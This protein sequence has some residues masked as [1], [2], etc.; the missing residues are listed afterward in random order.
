MKNDG[1]IT[2][3]KDFSTISDYTEKQKNWDTNK[4]THK[5]TNK[6]THTQ[7]NKQK[8]WN[9]LQMKVS[10]LTNYGFKKSECEKMSNR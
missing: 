7:T 9:W 5:Q 10:I 8:T 6:Q 3:D 1:Y 4:H 2:A